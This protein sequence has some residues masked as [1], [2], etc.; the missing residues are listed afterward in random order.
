MPIWRI[1]SN[2]I[3]LS[4]SICGELIKESLHCIVFKRAT[5]HITHVSNMCHYCQEMGIPYAESVLQLCITMHSIISICQQH[6]QTIPLFTN[7]RTNENSWKDFTR[8]SMRI[9]SQCVSE[10]KIPN[11]VVKLGKP[12]ELPHNFQYKLSKSISFGNNLDRKSTNPVQACKTNMNYKYDCKPPSS[13]IY[14]H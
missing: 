1:N 9:I 13:N 4:M 11:C 6:L 10:K 2:R 12:L 5:Y 3:S 7:K 14:I 8:D